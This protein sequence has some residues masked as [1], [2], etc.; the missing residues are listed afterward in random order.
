MGLNFTLCIYQTTFLDILPKQ[1]M[2]KVLAEVCLTACNYF[3]ICIMSEVMESS[4]NGLRLAIYNSH[5]YNLCRP[6]RQHVVMFLQRSQTPS[7]IRTFGGTVV[8]GYT[9]FT[10]VLRLEYNVVNFLK[11]KS[12]R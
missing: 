5:W 3:Y 12:I 4:N 6:A 9:H 8:L 2:T 1:K 7:H 10:R 11:L